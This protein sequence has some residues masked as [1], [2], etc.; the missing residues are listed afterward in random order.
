MSQAKF[1]IFIFLTVGAWWVLGAPFSESPISLGALAGLPSYFVTHKIQPSTPSAKIGW[2][3]ALVGLL[4]LIAS[5]WQ[6]WRIFFF[7]AFVTSWGIAEVCHDFISSKR[8][9]LPGKS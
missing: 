7:F 8:G 3:L 4:A 1:W 9:A 5:P 6:N 2:A